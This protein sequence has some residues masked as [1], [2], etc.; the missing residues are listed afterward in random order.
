V[1]PLLYE[2]S[3]IL[4]LLA[5]LTAGCAAVLVASEPLVADTAVG[6]FEGQPAFSEGKALGYFIWKDGETWKLRWTTFG[7]EH[8]FS[9]RV[10]VE[11][12]EIRSFKRIDVDTERTVLA[13][14]RP[15]RVVRGP[16]GRV[17]GRTAGR[18]PVVAS[19]DEDKIEKENE[20]V[21]RFLTRTDDDLDGLDFRVTDSTAVIRFVL[22]IDEKPRPAEV[23]VGRN[24][25]KPN[26]SPV[27]VRLR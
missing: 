2:T 8:R 13:P 25:F 18:P 26:E 17:R 22:E 6:R 10:A 15:G 3:Q 4:K 24:N 23:E 5:S 27:V 21:I 12:G 19:R 9:G 20:R 14:G 7:A 11:G 1:T 16:G